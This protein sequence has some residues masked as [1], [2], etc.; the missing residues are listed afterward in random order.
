MKMYTVALLATAA[1]GAASIGNASAMPL[2]VVQAAMGESQ[3]QDVRVVCNRY[4]RCYNNRRAYRSS[5]S[6]YAPGSYGP[7][8]YDR[9]YYGGHRY[10]YYR[11]PRV[12]IGIGPL[13]FGVW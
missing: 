12:G 3:V 2:N 7:G 10:G 1:M 6:Y 9:G 11:G 13:G 8:Y 4:H 5:R